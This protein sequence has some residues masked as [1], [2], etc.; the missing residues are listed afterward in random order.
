MTS[1]LSSSL[2][3]ILSESNG[4]DT[5]KN[6]LS[7]SELL[8]IDIEIPSLSTRTRK[9]AIKVQNNKEN[10]FKNNFINFSILRNN[11]KFNLKTQINSKASSSSI[12]TTNEVVYFMKIIL[13]EHSQLAHVS[14]INNINA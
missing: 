11:R 1:L 5:I 8:N 13:H 6:S 4:G 3:S 7:S 2:S 10:S 12:F 9:T 14:P